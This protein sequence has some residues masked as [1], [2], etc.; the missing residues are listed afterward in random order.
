M[1][2]QNVHC[3]FLYSGRNLII[4]K[5]YSDF[6]EQRIGSTMHDGVQRKSRHKNRQIGLAKQDVK[7]KLNRNSKAELRVCNVSINLGP[8]FCQ[9]FPVVGC[10]HPYYILQVQAVRMSYE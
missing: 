6:T 9:L 1:G 7:T 2:P 10:L 5:S 3:N 4:Q 8:V